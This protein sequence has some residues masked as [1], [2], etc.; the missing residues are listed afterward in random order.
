MEWSDR[1]GSM[2]SLLN[3]TPALA[4]DMSLHGPQSDFGFALAYGL[5]NTSTALDP[6]PADIQ[7]AG[8]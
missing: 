3:S 2:Y 4:K 7:T 1:M 5:Q 6:Y 8:G